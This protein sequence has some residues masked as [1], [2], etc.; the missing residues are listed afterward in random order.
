GLNSI[1]TTDGDRYPVL[2]SA[3]EGLNF[4]VLFYG[5]NNEQIRRC[6]SYQYYLSLKGAGVADVTLEQVNQW[7]VDQRF[8]TATRTKE[9]AIELRLN[10]N[11]N[12]GVTDAN[13]VAWLDWWKL[14][15]QRF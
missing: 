4:T 5:C 7:N 12:G 11:I 14:G 8:G 1:L 2:R 6:L 15:L 13:F 10:A 9:G 3:Q